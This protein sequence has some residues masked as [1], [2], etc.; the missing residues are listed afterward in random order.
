MNFSASAVEKI[1][2]RS[3]YQMKPK[4]PQQNTWKLILNVDND[5]TKIVQFSFTTR[6]RKAF[7]S[8]NEVEEP[9]RD[10]NCTGGFIY[11][12]KHL[13]FRNVRCDHAMKLRP[14]TVYVKRRSVA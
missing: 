7:I 2:K 13:V 3:K 12:M 1:S 8:E 11:L 6:T 9:F 14:P 4:I 5:M 10:E